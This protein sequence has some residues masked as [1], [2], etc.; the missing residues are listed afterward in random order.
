MDPY[1]AS[2]MEGAQMTAEARIGGVH[3][4][5][6]RLMKF[7]E[8]GKHVP[9][10]ELEVARLAVDSLFA[11]F[12]RL[13]EPAEA[14]TQTKKPDPSREAQEVVDGFLE[15]VVGSLNLDPNLLYEREK[16][17]KVLTVVEYIS[18]TQDGSFRIKVPSR[19]ARILN[20][21]F[22]DWA[23]ELKDQLKDEIGFSFFP[24]LKAHEAESE[25][26]TE[27]EDV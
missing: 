7:V 21:Q 26:E 24:V 4:H 20:A 15:E 22:P 16:D 25:Y 23:E 19:L 14:Q 13:A 10:T 5:L 3:G 2:E 18:Q 11:E 9:R 6:D 17:T 8:Q 12:D 1:K 27:L